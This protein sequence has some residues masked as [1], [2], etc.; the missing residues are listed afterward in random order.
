MI[1]D[2][3]TRQRVIASKHIGD[4]IYDA[5]SE[6]GTTAITQEDVVI[7]GQW[8]DWTGSGGV[9]TKNQ[10]MKITPNQ[11]QGT[12]AGIEGAKLGNLNERGIDTNNKRTR[13]RRVYKQL[14]G[15]QN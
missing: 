1:I 4:I 7:I 14:D 9:N 8:S 15:C 6:T 2:N 5:K 10:L 3:I 11:F 12:D 13:T